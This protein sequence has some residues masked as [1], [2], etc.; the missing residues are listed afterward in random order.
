MLRTNVNLVH[1]ESSIK[2]RVS[3][4][5]IMQDRL[6]ITT[7]YRTSLRIDIYS[8]RRQYSSFGLADFHRKSRK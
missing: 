3:L 4:F 6:F 5:C 2:V 1:V 8:G 7:A